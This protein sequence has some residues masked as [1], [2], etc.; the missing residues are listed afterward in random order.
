MDTT[1]SIQGGDDSKPISGKPPG[2]SRKRSTSGGGGLL[3]KLPFMRSA[4]EHRHSMS[5]P[6]PDDAEPFTPSPSDTALSSNQQLHDSA[7]S[8]M[9]QVVLKQQQQQ[10]TRRRRG[11]LRKVALLGRGA[12]RERRESRSAGTDIKQAIAHSIMGDVRDPFH[13][14]HENKKLSQPTN[15]DVEEYGLG[16]SDITPRPSMDGFAGRP[17]AAIGAPLSERSI[18]LA[19]ETSPVRDP[20]TIQQQGR[21]AESMATSPVIGYSTTDDEDALHMGPRPAT[22]SMSSSSVCSLSPPLRG[23]FLLLQ[24]LALFSDRTTYSVPLGSVCQ[25]FRPAPSPPS[26]ADAPPPRSAQNPR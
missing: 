26:S 1:P 9:S 19:L 16:I 10:K 6:S 2:P 21:E 17:T 13:S 14:G 3:S 11:S 7:S 25:T 12:Q 15:V 24:P 23:R 22:P 20:R 4:T 18:A 5:R 8:S